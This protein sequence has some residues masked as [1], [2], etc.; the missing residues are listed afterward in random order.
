MQVGVTVSHEHTTAKAL[1]GW[2]REQ[3]LRSG[4][5]QYRMR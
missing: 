2:I 4:T 5:P 1:H 3:A